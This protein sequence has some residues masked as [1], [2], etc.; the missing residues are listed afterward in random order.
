MFITWK[1]T[2]DRYWQFKSASHSR[3]SQVS[4]NKLQMLSYRFVWS[5]KP[6]KISRKIAHKNVKKGGIG[7]PEIKTVAMAWKLTL[8]R[9]IQNENK[10]WKNIFDENFPQ[11]RRLQILGPEFQR[12]F[13]RY[14]AFWNDVFGSYK[15][16][17]YK[18][19]Q[20]Q[21]SELLSEPLFF[22][23]RI[24]IGNE[25]YFWRG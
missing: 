15:E 5:K 21:S 14:N 19:L 12:K 17:F 2:T 11:W 4:N 24:K 13:I 22:N 9:N 18:N 20:T 23:E 10:K 25:H 3:N 7:I 8:F 1:I 6:G 16:F